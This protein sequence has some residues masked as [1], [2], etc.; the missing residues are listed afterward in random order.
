MSD[1]K[2]LDILIE[3]LKKAKDELEKGKVLDF[4]SRLKAKQ[5]ND[6][7][8]IETKQAHRAINKQPLTAVHN[9]AD[10]KRPV[11]RGKSMAGIITRGYKKDPEGQAHDKSYGGGAYDEHAKVLSAL[12]RQPKLNLT[13]DE[14]KKIKDCDHCGTEITA[15]HHVGTQ[16]LPKE[17]GFDHDLE[18]YN[19]PN[20]K[21]GTT[22]TVKTP[23][24]KLHKSEQFTVS[25][26]GQWILK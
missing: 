16:K 14:H 12:K 1:L 10:P 19:C 2:V 11:M 21:C 23:H 5:V 18:L 24:E 6:P 13:K 3:E 25:G 8:V 22:V 17:T 7:K 4:N 20:N 15:D 9:E 26:N